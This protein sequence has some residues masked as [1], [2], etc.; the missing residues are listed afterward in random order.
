M[1][2]LRVFD[3]LGILTLRE[4]IPDRLILRLSEAPGKKDLN[5]SRLLASLRGRMRE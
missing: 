2:V 5:S 3:E 1:W 4:P